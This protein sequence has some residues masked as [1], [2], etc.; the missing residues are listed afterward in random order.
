MPDQADLQPSQLLVENLSLFPHGPALDIAMGSGRNALFLAEN[1]FTVEGVDNSVEA[2]SAA[3]QQA[4]LRNLKLEARVA[5]LEQDFHIESG[6]YAL[7]IVFNYL[8]R[9]LFPRL[10]SG[11]KPQGIIV[12]ET[13]TVD[14]VRFGRPH[15]PDFLLQYNE[16]LDYFRDFRCLSYREGIVDNTA[17][18]ASLIALKPELWLGRCCRSVCT[19]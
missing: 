11:L 14:Q 18:K 12:Y 3:R 5:D 10:K 7:I 13:F 6:K 1:G 17:A 2:V 9:D 8:Q 19:A 15:N 4:R 16:L